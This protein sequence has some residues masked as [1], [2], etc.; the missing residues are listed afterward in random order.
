M[1][2]I[3]KV[4]LS[5][6]AADTDADRQRAAQEAK[7]ILSLMNN[8]PP[9]GDP[10]PV[11]DDALR[12]KVK[13]VL[14]DIGVPVHHLGFGHLITAICICTK[15]PEALQKI[16]KDLY[17]EVAKERNTTPSRVERGIRHSIETAVDNAEYD[18][19]VRFFGN[20]ISINRGKPTNQQFIATIAA[21]ILEGM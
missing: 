13:H 6:I 3:E 15:R 12:S 16:T 9:S 4:M 7:A 20:S 11:S 10:A 1:T 19:L 17:P 18:N 14:L 21:Y 5:Y 2:K 8:S